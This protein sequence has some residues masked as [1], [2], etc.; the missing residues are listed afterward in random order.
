[1]T[2]LQGWAVIGLLAM[3]CATAHLQ[4]AKPG[5]NEWLASAIGV[6]GFWCLAYAI[7]AGIWRLFT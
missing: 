5:A 7:G 3:C 4:W 1:M 6:G 2:D